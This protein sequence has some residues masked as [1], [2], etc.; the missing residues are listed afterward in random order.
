M[1][2]GIWFCHCHHNFAGFG[3]GFSLMVG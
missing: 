3:H 1:L 2:E